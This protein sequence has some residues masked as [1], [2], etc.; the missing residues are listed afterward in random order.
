MTVG[1]LRETTYLDHPY[2]VADLRL[3]PPAG[4]PTK[5]FVL[6]DDAVTHEVRNHVVFVTARREQGSDLLGALQYP[7][8][9]LRVAAP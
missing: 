3:T 1:A 6:I 2:V 7:A 5:D 9:R 8:R 4:T